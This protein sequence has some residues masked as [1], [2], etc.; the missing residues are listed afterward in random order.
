[1]SDLQEGEMVLNVLFVFKDEGFKVH[2]GTNVCFGA[3]RGLGE[4]VLW[5][6]LQEGHHTLIVPALCSE[7][8][9]VFESSYTDW[10]I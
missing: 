2:E 9:L 8:S 4:D 3:Q 1:M 7:H 10:I 5:N 6:P